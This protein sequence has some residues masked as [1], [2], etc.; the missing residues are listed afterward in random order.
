MSVAFTVPLSFLPNVISYNQP[1]T[2]LQTAGTTAVRTLDA[3]VYETPV[4]IKGKVEVI[5]AFDITHNP[6]K[7][8]LV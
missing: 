1:G 3:L 5:H 6:L 4:E 8:K 7:P 2:K